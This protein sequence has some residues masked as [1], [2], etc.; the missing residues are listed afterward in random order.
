MDIIERDW[1]GHA[2]KLRAGT[3]DSASYRQVLIDGAFVPL[4]DMQDVRLVVDAGAN[5]GFATVWFLDTFPDCEVMAIEPE[6]GNFA[7]MC[8]NIGPHIRRVVPLQGALWPNH[9]P[10]IVEPGK[11]RD[12]REWSTQV[13]ECEPGECYSCFGFSVPNLLKTTTHER[14]DI[15]KIDIEGAE[16]KL[17]AESCEW[18]DHVRVLVVELH[19]DSH[20]GPASP[21]FERAIAGRG[22][23]VMRHGE[24]TFCWREF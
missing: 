4:A 15:L 6:P 14:I 20:F 10:L 18:L 24:L 8:E 5:V 13:R 7:A 1:F 12:G 21:V 23:T 11:F 16:A 3:S 2:L 22:F 17:F 19:D 9:A